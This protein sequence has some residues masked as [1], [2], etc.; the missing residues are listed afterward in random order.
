M[1]YLFVLSFEEFIL[2]FLENSEDLFILKF[3]ENSEDIF[4]L[5]LH[6]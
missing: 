2:K 3:L 4:V 5:I 6:A 1:S